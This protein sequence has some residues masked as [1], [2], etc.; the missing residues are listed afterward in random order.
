MPDDCERAEQLRVRLRADEQRDADEPD[1]RP[2]ASRRPLDTL[3][4]E[5]REREQRVEDRHRRLDDRREAGVDPRLAPREQPE[6]DRRVD[7]R[8]RRR[9]RPSAREARRASRACRSQPARRSRARAPRARAA[10]GS[11]STGESSRTATLMN[12]NEL[13]Q[14]RASAISITAWRRFT[15]NSNVRSTAPSREIGAVGRPPVHWPPE[16]GRRAA[17]PP[18]PRS[19]RR[20]V[21]AYP[22]VARRGAERLRAGG[23]LAALVR[24]LRLQAL[25]AAP[26]PPAV[27]AAS[28]CCRARARTPA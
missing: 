23:L 17:S 20:G 12:M 22:G 16:L 14:I 2:R 9:A 1:A 13:P 18:R 7:E 11:A 27:D 28:A 5:E 15:G 19:H 8:R 25:G 10:R 21:R 3:L 24:A 4:V 6:R 26:A